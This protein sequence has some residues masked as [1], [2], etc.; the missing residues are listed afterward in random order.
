VIDAIAKRNCG[1]VQQFSGA[2]HDER[3]LAGVE[4]IYVWAEK[5][6]SY[7]THKAPLARIGP[8]LL[9]ADGV[10]LRRREAQAK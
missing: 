2:L 7:L 5:N 9:A 4:D 8:G 10:V 6:Q 1:V 3:W